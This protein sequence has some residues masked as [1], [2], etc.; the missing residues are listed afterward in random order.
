MKSLVKKVQAVATTLRT[1]SEKTSSE[2]PEPSLHNFT[3]RVSQRPQS[4]KQPLK[5]SSVL[6]QKLSFP[7]IKPSAP[8]NPYRRPVQT[9]PEKV[10]IQTKINNSSHTDFEWFGT[11]VSKLVQGEV[12]LWLQNVN[13]IDISTNFNIFMEQLSYMQ[14]YEI[15]FLSITETKL[16]PYN[17]YVSE[18]IEATMQRVYEGSTCNLSNQFLNNE[19]THQYG[20]VLS[21]TFNDI[22]HRVAGKG[23]DKLGRFNWIDFY[24]ANNYLRIYT[25][26]RINSGNDPSSGDDTCWSHQRLALLSDNCTTDPRQQVVL[27]LL[28]HIREDIKLKRSILVCGDINEN[29]M[30]NKGFNK[31]MTDIGLTNLIQR[32]I[33]ESK[34]RTHNR[35]KN[36]IDGLWASPNLL[37]SVV[38]C[39]IAPF[40]FLFPADHRGIF[41]DLNLKSF[42]D[43]SSPHIPPPAYRRL[44]YT[45]PKRVE[46]YSDRALS[47]WDLQKM[48]LRIHQLEQI[49]PTLPTC[50]KEEIVNKIDKEIND[51]MIA[52]E[53]KC[54]MVGRHCTTLFSKELKK[55][56]RQHRQCRC[57]LSNIL[58][59]SGSGDNSPSAIQN[60]VLDLRQSKRALKNCQKNAD[61]HR[62]TMYD[63]IAKDT[64]LMHPTRAKKKKSIIKQLKHCE[65]SRINSGKIRFATKGPRSSGIS[66][67]LIPDTASYTDEE[68][69]DPSFDILNIEWIW[70]RTQ[71]AN[72]KDI[73]Q[74]KRIDDID[75]VISLVTQVLLKHFSQSSETP[76]ANI[77]WKKK[78]SDPDFQQTLLDGSFQYDSSLPSEVNELLASFSR[79]P[80]IKD[81]PLLPT[82]K[83]FSH[84]V[85]TA[86]ESTSSSPSG[87]HYGHYKS[88]LHS[89]PR[90]LKGIFKVM[91]IALKHGLVPDRWKNTV[92]TLICKDNNTPYIHRLRPLH[93]VEAEMQ[94]FSKYQWSHRLINQAEH[95]KNISPSQYGGRKNKQAQSSV[96][97]TIITFDL[98][99]QLRLNFSFNDDD[100][101]ANY[102]RE[103][104]HLSAAETRSHGLSY[105]AGKLLIDITSK[106]KFFI[107]TKNGVSSSHYSFTESQPVWGLGQGI[108]WAGSCWQ[109]TATSI[110]NCLRK[111][112]KGAT[113]VNPE[114]DISVEQFMKFFIDDTTKICNTTDKNRTLLE[115]T[116]HNMQKHSNFIL[117]TGGSLALDKCRFFLINFKFDQNHD[118]QIL[119]SDELTGELTIT[120]IIT[121]N[122]HVIK[123]VDSHEARKTLGCFVSPSHNQ[124]PQLEAL[125]QIILAWKHSMTFSS[126]SNELIL[127]AYETVLKPKIV[128]RLSTTSLSFDQC[129]TL[130]KI[131][132]PLILHAHRAHQTFPKVILEAPSIY[133]GFN[134]EHFYDT[135]GYEKLKFFK[136]HMQ[137]QDPTGEVMLLSLQYTQMMLGIEELFFNTSFDNYSFLVD[138]TWLTHLWEFLDSK[139]LS[140]EVKKKY[141]IPAQREN[142]K[143]IMDVLHTHFSHQDLIKI[144]KIRL[145]LKLLF[146]SDV[147]DNVGRHILPDIKFGHTYR[148]SNLNFPVQTYSRQWLSIWNKACN[149]LQRYISANSLGS[150][151]K[152]HFSWNT[153]ISPCKQFIY[154]RHIW[155]RKIPSSNVF[156]PSTMDC[157]PEASIPIDI[158]SVERGIQVISLPY[159][160]LSLPN[161]PTYTTFTPFDLFGSFA[162]QD[163]NAVVEAIRTNKTRLCCDG[164]VQKTYGSF[165]YGLAQPRSDIL[166]FEQ[167]APVHGDL[168]QITSTRCE[169]MG[170]LA[171]LEYLNYLTSKYT[172]HKKHFIL[173]IA[174]NSS[175]ISAPL[176]NHTSIKYTFSPDM[177]IILH[178]KYLLQQLPFRIKFNHIKGHQDKFKPYDDLSTL[179][180][181]NVKMDTKAKE[182]FTSPQDTPKYSTTYPS[183]PGEAVSISD[184]HSRIVKNFSYNIRRHAIGYKAEKHLAKA[185]NIPQ[186]RLSLLDWKNFSSAHSRQ[187]R[188]IKTFVTKSIYKHLPTCTRQ[189]R[190]KQIESD[191]CTLCS[192]HEES[193]NHLF[194][195]SAPCIQSYRRK[196]IKALRDELT[197]LGTDPYLQRHLM[198]MILQFTNGFE[199]TPI[200]HCTENPESVLALNEQV[201]IGID[202]FLRGTIVW[203]L[204][205]AQE[206]FF[207]SQGNYKSTG[208]TWAKKLISYLFRTSH[209]IWT[210]RC[211]QVAALTDST[212]EHQTRNQCQTLLI[213]LSHNPQRLPVD[214]R[215]LLKRKPHFT[216]T[217]TLRALQSWAQRVQFG[218]SQANSGQ[219]RSVSDIRNWFQQLQV[220]SPIAV[221]DEETITFSPQT[222]QLER[223]SKSHMSEIRT[224][225]NLPYIPYQTYTIPQSFT[226]TNT[227]SSHPTYF[228]DI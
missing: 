177:D 65:K 115:Q 139:G 169:L 190:W 53:K 130:V 199:V 64:L 95:F 144:N 2:S 86:K 204:G 21:A 33:G 56:L 98:H 59:K 46:A 11:Q 178:I 168:D 38:R 170:I 157:L 143:F 176:K 200:L 112:C 215:H 135:Q 96:L 116:T 123:R 122:S 213:Q 226:S 120:N 219:K 82:W 155:F 6:Q 221:N 158:K 194:Q 228:R 84:F 35:G 161:D 149:V 24:G 106:Q 18:N 97:N 113:L 12:R 107:K 20:G 80:L 1:I 124:K 214:S 91:C 134:F 87:R 133:A 52:S 102:D 111:H 175:A 41:L 17:A 207:R 121:G 208:D 109:F 13:G 198:R 197:S 165:A 69:N 40:N 167:N 114:G 73:H 66:Y 51:L 76:L 179:A 15:S 31:Q 192:E 34:I 9:S 138:K 10:E 137:M 26:Y 28:K 187:P 136:Y 126:L 27:D 29:V 174:D 209:M 129:E 186:Y 7:I 180:K 93:I 90:I 142:D 160:T 105:E 117:S 70:N 79:K 183:L 225:P 92:T 151:N 108:S 54:C 140:I 220:P 36:I 227:F 42:L 32:E 218:L 50:G 216:K 152:R 103:L 71:K 193:P 118:P 55:A 100:L 68:Q 195:C 23:K 189:K 72:G 202:N 81:I 206:A 78:L 191:L 89:A 212:F 146:L 119:T 25:I 104:A 196:Q 159:S 141:L 188:N 8:T 61:S 48:D 173:L 37:S 67:I 101:R 85:Q 181:L 43:I 14:R 128:Y 210:E 16:N 217:S 39:G 19:D 22:S 131:I 185:L 164:S 4:F 127:Q 163:E 5:V 94:F 47:L 153:Y 88:L 222:E 203:R 205:C 166:L 77:Y 224:V 110:E 99:R 49:L 148:I 145:H 62:E 182:F 132:R 60:A 147:A 211:T 30:S 125:K 44:K 223:P 45:I 154:D 3:P 172:F 83:N 150:W 74:W 156:Q 171:C 162:T 63:E 58:L 57:H 75:T 184:P 201:K